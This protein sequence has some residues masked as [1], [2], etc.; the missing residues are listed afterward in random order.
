MVNNTEN[1]RKFITKKEILLFSI[2][3]LICIIFSAIFSLMPDGEKIVIESGSEELYSFNMSELKKPKKITVQ[4]A[5]ELEVIIQVD[6]N[7]AVVIDAG[8]PDKTC[9]KSGR[10]SKSGENI[11]CLPA[12]IV[13]KITG[14]NGFDAATY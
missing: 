9:V 5:D 6:S 11:I 2:I 12:R 7:G 3:I 14:G 1:K 8:C 4:G 13:V 10:I